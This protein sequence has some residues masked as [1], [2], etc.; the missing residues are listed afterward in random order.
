MMTSEQVAQAN[1]HA[2]SMGYGASPQFGY[3]PRT[4]ITPMGYGAG[5]QFGVGALSTMNSAVNFASL[6]GL[7]ALLGKGAIGMTGL[8]STAMGGALAS[9]LGKVATLTGASLPL[10]ASFGLMMPAM[11]GIGA[12]ATGAQQLSGVQNT[13]DQNFGNRIN[14]GG[15]FGFGMSRQATLGI[16]ETMRSLKAM[17]SLMTDMG[18]LQGILDKVSSMGMMQAVRNA[19]EFKTK[20]TGMVT[21]LREMSKDLGSTMEQ[22]MPFLQSSVRQGFLDPDHMRRNVM[23]GVATS[24]IGIGMRAEDVMQMQ[25]QGAGLIRS[26]GGDSR[27]GALGMQSMVGSLSVAQQQGIISQE[28]VTRITGQTGAEGIK[29][30][31][32]MVFGAQSQL[33][34]SKGAGRFMTAALAARD[35]S[36]NFT[37]ALDSDMLQK[38]QRG[39]ITADE[40]MKRGNKMLSGLSNENALSFMNA[41]NKGMGAEAAAQLGPGGS[42]AAVNAILESL[43]AKG[44]E[45]QRFLLSQMTGM[46][47]DA[48]DAA[49][50]ILK[51]AGRLQDEQNA[52]IREAVIRGRAGAYFKENLTLGGK[53]HHAQT[54]A[55]SMFVDPFH[56]AGAGVATRIG[57]RFDQAMMDFLY[58]DGI[59]QK[60]A[61][62]PG[63]LMHTFGLNPF[64]DDPY[65]QREG[66]A[67]R[68]FAGIL[69]KGTGAAALTDEQISA[70]SLGYSVSSVSKYAGE[71]G[72]LGAVLGS[73]GGILGAAA[74]GAVGGGVGAVAGLLE[75]LIQGDGRKLDLNRSVFG[76]GN[77]SGT[78]AL[79]GGL[80]VFKDAQGR[81]YT[82]AER[83]DAQARIR[84]A[85]MSMNSL[86]KRLGGTMSD[87]GAL[88][89]GGISGLETLAAA[90][91]GEEGATATLAGELM[92]RL[93]GQLEGGNPVSQSD[94][95]RAQSNLDRLF[96]GGL[97]RDIFGEHLTN[98]VDVGLIFSSDTASSIMRS[99]SQDTQKDLADILGNEAFRKELRTANGNSRLIEGARKFIE[100]RIGRKLSLTNEQLMALA[101]DISNAYGDFEGILGTSLFDGG[102]ERAADA[103]FGDVAN[104]MRRNMGTMDKYEEQL[105]GSEFQNI[106]RGIGD[107]GLRSSLSGGSL[108]LAAVRQAAGSA[109]GTDRLT[110]SFK[111]AFARKHLGSRTTEKQAL[112]KLKSAGLSD[113]DINKYLNNDGTLTDTERAG[114]EN[115]LAFNA[116]MG[117]ELRTNM[118]DAN[119]RAKALGADG[120]LDFELRDAHRE[121]MRAN[122]DF[123]R[124]VGD[125]VPQLKRAADN[126]TTK[127]TGS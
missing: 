51:D 79:T 127:V 69:R 43:G 75:D 113:E 29:S 126:A 25:E 24:R 74:G 99:G 10:A 16:T 38:M 101:S 60:L 124:A 121:A 30:L 57:A 87:V 56:R 39:E 9:G 31:S 85:G 86:N 105:A 18:E 13:L 14:M 118:S 70:N 12:L 112:Q 27:I 76:A 77:V 103:I 123:I 66:A 49:L 73:A 22:A 50:R 119:Q 34:Q 54:A 8:G 37:G 46:R 107:E 61:S 115:V 114:V 98:D 21:A 53:M 120:Q 41:M 62:I 72:A 44:E 17:P 52:Q 80:R 102:G 36:G 92:T 63:G 64:R 95:S 116:A 3:E 59:G 110:T 108:D 71:A 68:G 19:S 28:D 6:A 93:R 67:E 55:Q 82:V 89:G 11:A 65:T 40:L 15:G 42:A 48:A 20:F 78:G 26:M 5:S 100:A 97:V 47:Q 106:V 4:G 117:S 90:S 81:N 32:S 2:F 104:E 84:S 91:G 1:S 58:A 125:V 35:K 88:A 109:T 33:F 122:T 94:V 45:A 111:K 23:R 96:S 83:A 7:G